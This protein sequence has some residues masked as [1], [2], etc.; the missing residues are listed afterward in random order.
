MV[1]YASAITMM[2]GPTNIKLSIFYKIEKFI[3]VITTVRHLP[4]CLAVLM[5]I[6]PFPYILV[7]PPPPPH[8]QYCTLNFPFAFS[9]RNSTSNPRLHHAY[10]VRHI[11]YFPHNLHNLKCLIIDFMK[12]NT[13]R[14]HKK[15]GGIKN[16]DILI[17]AY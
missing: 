3:T 12:I 8:C 11:C 7:L 16:Y 14:G 13:A 6:T 17:K 15:R 5:Q 1:Y 4:L 10:C 9:D 2:H